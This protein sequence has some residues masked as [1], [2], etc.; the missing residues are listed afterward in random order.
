MREKNQS[1]KTN[2]EKI[3]ML[4]GRENKAVT[5]TVFHMFKKLKN[6]HIKLMWRI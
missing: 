5:I 1:I 2:P 3:Q 4:E 6:K